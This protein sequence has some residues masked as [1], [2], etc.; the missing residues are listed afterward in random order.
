MKEL[1]HLKVVRFTL[2]R[3]PNPYPDGELPWQVYH[4]VRN[5]IVRTCRLHGPTGPM[6][7]CKIEEDREFPDIGTWP[8]GDEPPIYFIVDDQYNHE[9]YLYAELYGNDAFNRDWLASIV[10]TLQEFPGW[11]IGIKNIYEGCLLI[12][13]NK[14][15]VH[16]KTFRKCRDVASVV[17]AARRQLRLGY[18]KWWQF[19]R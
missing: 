5:A 10:A 14:L 8:R 18:K 6:G 11:A 13:S 17:D 1:K 9:R 12:F 2:R 7:E 15:M 16:G 3:I 4:T 19:W